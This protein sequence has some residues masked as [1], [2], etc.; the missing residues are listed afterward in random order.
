MIRVE[1]VYKSFGTQRV[2]NGVSLY[3]KKESTSSV[4][5]PSGVGK[6]VLLKLIL[7][8]MQPDSGTV[9]VCG[10]EM[11]AA[12]SEAKR[13]RIRANL[14]VLFQSAALFDSMSLFDNIAFPLRCSSQYSSP[15]PTTVLGIFVCQ[16]CGQ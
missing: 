1:N 3:V 4:V 7:G 14:G 11:T 16:L 12:T 5:G 10:E 15:V 2:L 13:N 9:T 8:I 6:S